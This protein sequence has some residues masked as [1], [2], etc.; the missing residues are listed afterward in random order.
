QSHKKICRYGA[1]IDEHT[2]DEQIHELRIEGK[3][4]RYLLDFFSELFAAEQVKPQLKALK[5]L[6]TILG[7]FNDYGVQQEFLLQQL[8][9][10]T[11]PEQVAA[12]NGLVALLYNQQLAARNKVMK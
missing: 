5:R 6:Q 8:K 7:D 1:E 3:K 9:A 4:L 2:P 10:N 12:V 11:P